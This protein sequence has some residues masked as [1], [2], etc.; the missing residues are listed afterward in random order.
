M[1]G[2]V[3]LVLIAVTFWVV[4]YANDLV[5]QVLPPLWVAT[6]LGLA[7]GYFRLESTSSDKAFL[8]QLVLLLGSFTCL[9]LAAYVPARLEWLQVLIAG[10]MVVPLSALIWVRRRR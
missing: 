1:A 2:V 6:T 8:L 3:T 10:A 5:V 7:I 9:F 4:V